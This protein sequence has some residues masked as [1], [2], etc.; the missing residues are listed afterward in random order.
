MAKG[1]RSHTKKRFRAIKR[2]N[3]FKPVEDLRLKR[4]AEAQAEAANKAKVGNHMDEDTTATTDDNAMTDDQ[5]KKISTGGARNA[6]VSRKLR[7]KK[8]KKTHNKW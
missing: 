2:Q 1:L 3:V 4:L 7:M 8:K 6:Q 5:P